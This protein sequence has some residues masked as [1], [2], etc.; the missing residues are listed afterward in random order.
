MR[1]TK[2]MKETVIRFDEKNPTAE[3]TTANAAL[4]RRLGDYARS[5]PDL[6]Q[7]LDDDDFGTQTFVIDK[8]RISLR[9]TKPYS[10]ERR[11]NM[12]SYAKDNNTIDY[13]KRRT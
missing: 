2:E 9:L 13:V 10:D 3:I 4:K 1:I 6:C 11:Q 8:R 5:Y 7:L 12:S